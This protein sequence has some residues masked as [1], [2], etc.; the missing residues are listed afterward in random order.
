MANHEMG[1]WVKGRPQHT[2]ALNHGGAA[3]F[4][5]A[6]ELDYGSLYATVFVETDMKLSVVIPTAA[7]WIPSEV[8]K[9]I[10]VPVKGVEY[11]LA[12]A[13]TV[14]DV[15][16]GALVYNNSGNVEVLR[17]DSDKL[18]AIAV[19]VYAWYSQQRA[20]LRIDHES[21]F[22]FNPIGTLIRTAVSGLHWEE[23]GT[24]VTSR[25]CNYESATLS[26]ETD[27]KKLSGTE[28]GEVL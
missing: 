5:V 16:D 25:E 21:L 24:V 4:V 2:M 15:V 28:F 19:Y 20:T 7:R 14:T 3:D 27:F 10:Y 1:V 26:I 17:D 8:A 22:P 6:P 13:N 12:A 18:R 11:W 23:I 9:E